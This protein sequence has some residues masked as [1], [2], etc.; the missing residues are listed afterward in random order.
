LKLSQVAVGQPLK[1]RRW[2]VAVKPK[3]EELA[4]ETKSVC[5]GEVGSAHLPSKV[6]ARCKSRYFLAGQQ[7]RLFGARRLILSSVSG[8]GSSSGLGGESVSREYL[9]PLGGGSWGSSGGY[10][11]QAGNF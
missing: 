2:A 6:D 8:G 10:S 7:W 4:L 5:F 1:V 3:T 9:Q 11:E